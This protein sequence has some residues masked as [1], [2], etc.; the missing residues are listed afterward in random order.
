[1]RPCPSRS[2]YPATLAI[3]QSELSFLSCGFDRAAPAEKEA[4]QPPAAAVIGRW[5]RRS[6]MTPS[7]KTS[8]NRD[9]DTPGLGA[10]EV[11]PHV[12]GRSDQPGQDV[13]ATSAPHHDAGPAKIDMT[14]A[15]GL[16]MTTSGAGQHRGGDIESQDLC[17][18]T[19][20]GVAVDVRW[21]SHR[22][23]LLS[24]WLGPNRS[25]RMADG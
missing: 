6:T 3:V 18:G 24:Y 16:D 25:V 21:F 4:V 17:E 1:M 9:W 10:V 11:E 5:W 13:V 12:G 22:S 23:P 7:A 19:P 15:E 14:L 20:G 2:A 8:L